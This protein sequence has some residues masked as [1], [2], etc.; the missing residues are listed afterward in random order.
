MENRKPLTAQKML[1]FLLELQENGENLDN[2]QI[3][4]RYDRDEDE[5]NIFEVEED[6]YDMETNSKLETIML[7]TN[8]EEL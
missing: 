2:I 7:L 5:V 1:N 3:L 4:Y 8:S 6:L